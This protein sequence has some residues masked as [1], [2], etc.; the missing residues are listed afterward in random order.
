MGDEAGYSGRKALEAKMDADS[1]S[2][3]Q[4]AAREWVTVHKV[5]L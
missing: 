5:S 4:R 1:I 2:T 3:A